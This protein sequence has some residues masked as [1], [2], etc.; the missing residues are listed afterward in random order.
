MTTHTETMW[1]IASHCD[2]DTQLY[3]GTW[4]TESEAKYGHCRGFHTD[5][6]IDQ[7]CW[8]KRQEQGDR[9]VKVTMTYEYPTGE[10]K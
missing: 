3:T 7:K 10:L 4:Q 9:A 2:G 6:I 8:E 5:C 1:A